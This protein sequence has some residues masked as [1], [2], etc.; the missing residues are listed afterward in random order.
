MKYAKFEI[1]NRF[2]QD[3]VLPRFK[4][5]MLRGA[6]GHALKA[7][8]CAVRVK[9]CEPCI[10][11]PT[12][13]YARIF[14]VKPDYEKQTK[15]VNFPH[16]Y[17]LQCLEEQTFF[18]KDDSFDFSLI[19]FGDMT[20]YLPYFVYAFEQ[21]GQGGIG[22]KVDGQRAT[23][24]VRGVFYNGEMIYEE[25]RRTLPERVP[26]EQITLPDTPAEGISGIR[27]YFE[28]PLRVKNKGQ[29]TTTLDFVIL[30]RTL[31][32]RVQHLWQEFDGRPLELNEKSLLQ[33]AET[34]EA[35][36]P[37]LH[38][39]E[40]TRFSNRQQNR[41]NLGGLKGHI[42]FRGNLSPFIPLFDL[43]RLVHIGK[44]TSFGLGKLDYEIIT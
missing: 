12:C 8:I 2:H 25:N 11:R 14:E 41:Q 3:T 16:P 29:F 43:A 42:E 40:Q 34:V 19:L 35:Q 18:K 38:W 26:C 17:V 32:R 37:M 22:K 21:V 24:T 23:F 10:L 1:R 30:V 36:N 4:G 31:L 28:T 13:L 44:A 9:I 20:Q 5:S 6:M 7:T 27:V 15:Q 39:E 33:I